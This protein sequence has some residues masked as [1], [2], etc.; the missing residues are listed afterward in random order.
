MNEC[1]LCGEEGELALAPENENPESV[2][3]RP[4]FA[5]RPCYAEQKLIPESCQVQSSSLDH[6]IQY[7]LFRSFL[8]PHEFFLAIKLPLE[9]H[10]K[11]FTQISTSIFCKLS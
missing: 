9:E 3:L 6:L 8:R 4:T 7:F 2:L 11:K 5:Y 10:W 1:E